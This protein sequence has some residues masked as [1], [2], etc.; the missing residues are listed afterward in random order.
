MPTVI[1]LI[2][3]SR[4]YV[5]KKYDEYENSFANS[6]YKS[7]ENFKNNI[8]ELFRISIETSQEREI[9]QFL[10]EETQ[11]EESIS[12]MIRL[13]ETK[14]LLRQYLYQYENVEN[15]WIYS[16]K[17]DSIISC[18]RNVTVDEAVEKELAYDI[19]ENDERC[20]ISQNRFSVSSGDGEEKVLGI[21][22]AFPMYMENFNNVDGIIAFDILCD[23]I[24]DK[25]LYTENEH[26]AILTKTGA[27]VSLGNN[28]TA[29]FEKLSF[30]EILKRIG[31]NEYII[32]KNSSDTYC[33]VPD[34]DFDFIL[35]FS[36]GTESGKQ[37]A[38]ITLRMIMS[39]LLISLI[40]MIILSYAI[41]MVV[42]DFMIAFVYGVGVYNLN[43][44]QSMVDYRYLGKRFL[45]NMKKDTKMDEEFAVK[46]SRLRDTQVLALQ[47]QINPHFIFNTLNFVTL[48]IIQITKRDCAPSKVVSLLSDILYYSLNTAEFTAT[49]SDELEYAQKY[50]EIEM[51]KHDNS[52][53]MIM[54]VDENILD[55][56]CVKFSL[57]PILENCIM[58]GFDAER[59]EKGV[60]V[61]KIYKQ[62]NNIHIVIKNNGRSASNEKIHELNESFK[63]TDTIKRGR[64]IG[65]ANVNQRLKIIFGTSASMRVYNEQNG[66]A[67]EIVHPFEL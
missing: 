27:I 36:S 15:I 40:A 30:N 19:L 12:E 55:G 20:S 29:E 61:L 64:H 51:I 62:E 16:V 47:N 17:N 26:T 44:A 41:S 58:H 22:I 24:S 8:A 13:T 56:K 23:S 57:Q 9:L 31:K 52:F 14:N 45:L 21:T 43:D 35:L 66:F 28:D 25:I 60:I 6:S 32:E 5:N 53:E 2:V 65:L 4:L 46:M 50:V 7:A 10:E 42:F 48:M 37:L 59:C 38:V 18:V 49:L 33:Y 39:W 11:E 34:T 63:H 3:F 67:V 1:Y 54:D